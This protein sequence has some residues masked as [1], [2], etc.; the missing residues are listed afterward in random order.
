MAEASQAASQA[1]PQQPRVIR[2]Q[3]IKRVVIEEASQA[4]S[5]TTVRPSSTA[6]AASHTTVAGPRTVTV[7]DVIK[8]SLTFDER[9]KRTEDDIQGRVDDAFEGISS[10]LLAIEQTLQRLTDS[11]H[12]AVCKATRVQSYYT[13][14][15]LPGLMP[16]HYIQSGVLHLQDDS[17]LEEYSLKVQYKDNVILELVK[18]GTDAPNIVSCDCH[19]EQNAL[20]GVIRDLLIMDHVKT[21]K[22]KTGK[23]LKI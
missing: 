5:Q 14:S 7:D 23:T 11:A 4:A 9:L 22:R 20:R 18:N 1:A 17:G 16:N 12:T 6:E 2:R 3:P 13:E 19:F 21:T 8:M 15:I 10:R